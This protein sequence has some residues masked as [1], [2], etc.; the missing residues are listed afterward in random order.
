M[1]THY[2]VEYNYDSN[3]KTL[4][5]EGVLSFKSDDIDK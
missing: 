3:S 5:V 4:D 2:Y 1:K